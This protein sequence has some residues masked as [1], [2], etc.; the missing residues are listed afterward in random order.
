ML[1][2]KLMDSDNKS[3]TYRYY[4]EGKESYGEITV[5]RSTGEIEDFVLAPIE[6]ERFKWYFRHM[7]ARIRQFI[8]NDEFL[9][10]GLVAWY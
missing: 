5:S 4:P 10:S 3:V 7:Y 6:T 2:Y 1:R 9:E 8:E